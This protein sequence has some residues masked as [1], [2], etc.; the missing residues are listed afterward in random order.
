MWLGSWLVE[1]ARLLARPI[2]QEYDASTVDELATNPAESGK[3]TARHNLV[4]IAE[5]C[6]K[7]ASEIRSLSRSDFSSWSL[8]K[9][10]S[11]PELANQV[12]MCS[13]ASYVFNAGDETIFLPPTPGT[14][15]ICVIHATIWRSLMSSTDISYTPRVDFPIATGVTGGTGTSV[16]PFTNMSLT[17]PAKPPQQKHQPSPTP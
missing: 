14:A 11:E 16:A 1:E 3:L 2:L 8:V 5:A 17:C 15:V 12:V 10:N 6:R 7:G 9:L 4:E 13:D